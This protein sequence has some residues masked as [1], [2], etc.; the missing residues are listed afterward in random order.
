MPFRGKYEIGEPHPAAPTPDISRF[1]PGLEWAQEWHT[2]VPDI[3]CFVHTNGARVRMSTDMIVELMR[4]A[5]LRAAVFAGMADGAEK[6]PG[7]RFAVEVESTWKT[8][9]MPT[10]RGYAVLA[11]PAVEGA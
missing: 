1:D 6:F 3:V 4:D 5:R 9:E 8:N 2:S 7:K 10:L 11:E